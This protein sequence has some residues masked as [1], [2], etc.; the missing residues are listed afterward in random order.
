[1]PFDQFHLNNADASSSWVELHPTHGQFIEDF[2]LD[3]TQNRTIGGQINAFKLIGEAFRYTIPLTFVNSADKYAIEDWWRNQTE[4]AF[5]INISGTNPE[6]V[7][8]KIIN[9]QRPLNQKSNGQWN[10][11]DGILFLH[12]ARSPLLDAPGVLNNLTLDHATRGKLDTA[13]NVLNDSSV[14]EH[15][16]PSIRSAGK[17]AGV[18]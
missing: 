14:N 11:W 8:S 4:V 16:L 6:T 12:S 10:H 1:M 17:T 5:T 2:K 7:Y 15:V 18:P 3:Q 13:T 9:K